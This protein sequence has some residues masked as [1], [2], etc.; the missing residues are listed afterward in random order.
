MGLFAVGAYLEELRR[1]RNMTRQELSAAVGIS[2]DTLEDA[3]RGRRRLNGPALMRLI[4]LVDGSYEQV[5]ALLEMEE[6][7]DSAEDARALAQS[8]ATRPSVIGDRAPTPEELTA[9]L[10]ELA[11][12]RT[13]GDRD[14]ARRLLLEALSVGLDEKR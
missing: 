11:L 5:A 4:G 6:G 7:E 2:P 1:I 10:W 14:R 8:W 3:E 12:R 9:D 13:G